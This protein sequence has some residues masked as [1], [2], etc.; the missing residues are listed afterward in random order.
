[1]MVVPESMIVSKFFT[2]AFEPRIA[3]APVTCQKPFELS[4]VWYSMA[5]E[6]FVVSVPPRNSEE[7]D[8]ANLKPKTPALVLCCAI[9][10]LKNGF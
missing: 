6:Y 7:S 3:L 4:T 2:M 9:A 8:D 5:P 10:L 1:M